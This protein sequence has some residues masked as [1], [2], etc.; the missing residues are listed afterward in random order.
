MKRSDFNRIV[1]Q[2]IDHIN[3]TLTA[4][5]AEYADDDNVFRNFEAAGRKLSVTREKALQGMLIKHIVSVDDIIDGKAPYI[6]AVLDEKI[7]DIINYYILLKA[8]LKREHDVIYEEV[9]GALI[10][11]KSLRQ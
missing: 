5:G 8:M 6:D 10:E 9:E 3:R 1:Q 2:S 7:G 11:L 4:K